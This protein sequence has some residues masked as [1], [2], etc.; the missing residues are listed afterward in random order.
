MAVVMRELDV[1]TRTCGL[2]WF[3]WYDWYG[4]LV[5][6]TAKKEGVSELT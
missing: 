6:R 3:L 5:V 4:L 2:E 1:N